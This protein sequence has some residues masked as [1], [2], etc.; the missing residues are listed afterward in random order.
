MVNNTAKQLDNR[1]SSRLIANA[2]QPPTQSAVN[3]TGT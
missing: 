3:T 2:L 1:N